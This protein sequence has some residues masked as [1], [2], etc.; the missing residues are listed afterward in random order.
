ME[1]SYLVPAG[2]ARA[3]IV[4]QK[5]RFIAS[6]TPAFSVDEARAFLNSIRVEFPDATHHVPAFIIGH[7]DSMIAHCSDAGEPSGTAGRPALTV[8][9]GSGLGDVAV[10]VTRFFGGVKLGTGGL[11]RAYRDAV[12]AV[13]AVLP[14]A[15]KCKVYTVKILLPYALFERVR[16]IVTEHHGKI[17]HKVFAGDVTMIIRLR[18]DDFVPFQNVLRGVSSGKLTQIEIIETGEMVFPLG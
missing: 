6:A 12:K 2:K 17:V 14:L 4:V 16:S 1:E 8:L 11:A 13:L 5:S 7:G 15:Q 9:Q 10:V 18:V 3:E